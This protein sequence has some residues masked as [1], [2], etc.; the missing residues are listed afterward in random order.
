MLTKGDA[1]VFWPNFVMLFFVIAHKVCDGLLFWPDFVMLLF[2][3]AS[4]MWWFSVL[5]WFCDDIV[6]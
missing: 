3:V 5:T 6:F 4:K 1:L 2:V